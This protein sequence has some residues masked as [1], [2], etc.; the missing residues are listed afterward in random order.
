MSKLYLLTNDDPL[1]LLL[2][3]LSGALAS[4]VVDVLQIR[5]KNVATDIFGDVEA[6]LNI[7]QGH[8]VEVVMNDSLQLA[9]E[10]GIGLHLGQG[11][12][13]MVQ[14]RATLGD[15]ALI[16]RTCHDDLEL[17]KIA[18][19]EGASYAALGAVFASQTK[20]NATQVDVSVIKSAMT[21]GIDVCLIGGITL[22]NIRIL[23]DLLPTPPQYVA[24]TADIMGQ[25]PDKVMQRC[26]MWGDVLGAWRV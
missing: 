13:D 16:G 8:R 2:E 20:P 22:D 14:A 24:I 26:Q 3:K 19:K 18:K 15:Q 25:S 9:Q 17:V 10:F 1:P 11:D 4:G 6:I 21:Q 7:C 12:G 5:R 23:Q